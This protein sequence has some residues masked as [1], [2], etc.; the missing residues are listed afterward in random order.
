M[1]FILFDG[2]PSLVFLLSIRVQLDIC[3]QPNN[4]LLFWLSS[5]SH[6]VYSMIII[7]DFPWLSLSEH[8]IS[9]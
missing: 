8:K 2:R 5:D 1:V 7:L 9:S 6:Y 3:T 4:C